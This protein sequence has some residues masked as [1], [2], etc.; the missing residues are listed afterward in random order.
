M[1][2]HVRPIEEIIVT[3]EDIASGKRG[4][5]WDCPIAL[6][7]NRAFGMTEGCQYNE[8]DGCFVLSRHEERYVVEGGFVFAT[9]FDFGRPVEPRS[10]RLCRLPDCEDDDD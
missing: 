9:D 6:A 5:A 7:A 2:N 3:A 1:Q 8:S 4:A 10:F